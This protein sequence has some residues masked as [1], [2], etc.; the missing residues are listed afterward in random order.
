M[1]LEDVVIEASGTLEAAAVAAA[2]AGA[3]AGGA[4]RGAV[5]MLAV[6]VAA[7]G[8]RIDREAVSVALVPRFGAAR[9]YSY[10]SL[11]VILLSDFSVD[12]LPENIS[13]RG[14]GG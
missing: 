6:A 10:S 11:L 8:A 2:A 5:S 14:G 4:A 13:E 1:W 3:A 7:R 12:A 9:A